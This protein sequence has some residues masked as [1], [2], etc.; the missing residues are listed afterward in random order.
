MEGQCKQSLFAHCKCGTDV[1]GPGK[2]RTRTAG[3]PCAGNAERFRYPVLFYP[4]HHPGRQVYLSFSLSLSLSLFLFF[5]DEKIYAQMT[6]GTF[7]TRQLGSAGAKTGTHVYL[8]TNILL[9][10]I[11]KGSYEE[12]QEGQNFTTTRNDFS[13]SV[14]LCLRM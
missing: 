13:A 10:A 14:N 12:R 11:L 4:H 5:I 7:K 1:R 9:L 2:K 6:M 3:Q 8:T